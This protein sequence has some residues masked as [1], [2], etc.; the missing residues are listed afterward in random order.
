MSSAVASNRNSSRLVHSHLNKKDYLWY[1]VS[2][3]IDTKV[4]TKSICTVYMNVHSSL[5]GE[6]I[7][8]PTQKGCPVTNMHVMMYMFYSIPKQSF[9]F[10]YILVVIIIIVVTIQCYYMYRQCV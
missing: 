5:T 1:I 4:N 2:Y 10:N 8:H 9:F 7:E 6:T 3:F